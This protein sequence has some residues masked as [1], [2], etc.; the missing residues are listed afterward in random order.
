MKRHIFLVTVMSAA[1]IFRAGAFSD[2]DHGGHG[3]DKSED[4]NHDYK[5]PRHGQRDFRYF[6][7]EDRFL[8]SWYYPVQSLPPGLKKKYARTGTLAPGWQQR[9][10]PLPATVMARLPPVPPNCETGYADGYAVVY[11]RTT[12]VILDTVDLIG[13]LRAT[14]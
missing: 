4:K 2:H 6:R 8:L 12:R 5:S 9:V 13:R 11:D 10:Q 7:P 1:A 14:E 3:K